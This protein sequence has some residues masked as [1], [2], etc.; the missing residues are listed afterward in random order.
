MKTKYLLAA[1]AA[2]AAL[3]TMAT[4]AFAQSTGSA[5]FEEGTII[6][7][8]TLERDVAGVEIPD[9]PKA[10]VQIDSELIQR[11][12]PGQTINDTLNLVP[13][14]SF[15]N[16][17][18]FGSLGGSF[19]IR[20]FSSDRISQTFDGVPLNDSGNYALYTNQQLDPEI[21]EAATVSLG[22]TDVDSP[23]A[24]AA[25]GTINIRS[26]VPDDVMGAM[27][28][29]SYGNIISRGDPGDRPFLRAFGKIETGELTAGGL[30]AFFSASRA[31]NDSVFSN[32]GG[33][34]KQQYNAK[35]YQPIGVDGD[36]ISIAGHYNENRNN[37]NGSPFRYSGE[38]GPVQEPE[39]R[40]YNLTDG[41]PCAIDLPQTGVQDSYN[42]CGTPFERR[43]NPS[44]T[45]NVRI[46]SLFTLS[47]RLTLT[48]DP[49][50]QYV[51]ANGGGTSVGYEGFS[52]GGYTGG[53][54]TGDSR[55]PR[56]M[57]TDSEGNVFYSATQVYY[58]G[59]TDLNG[60]GDLLDFVTILSPS[61][62]R[63]NRYG[64]IANLIYELS[65]TQRV[66]LAYTFDR[67]RHRQTGTAGSLLGN[68]EPVDVFPIN[69]P[70][71]DANG[72]APQKR[73]RLSYATLHQVS[74]EYRGEFGDLTALVGLRAPFFTRDLNQYCVTT[75]SGGNVN[76][77]N[78]D[79]DTAAYVAANAD[80]GY[81]GPVSDK[82][83]YNKILPNVGFTYAIGSAASVFANF[84]KNLS[85]PGTD[86]LYGSL[87][88]GIAPAPETSDAFDVGVRYQSGSV[89]AQLS[90]WFNRYQNRLAS[91]YSPDCDCT[92]TRNLGQ[93]DKYGIDGSVAYQPI[94]A[95]SLYVFGS[96]L[97]SEIKDDVQT[98]PAS[99]AATAGKREAGAPKYMLGARAQT[100]LGPIQLGLQGKKTG[101]RFLNDINTIELPGYF[102]MDA[103]LRVAFGYWDADYE[104]AFLQ[105]NVTNILD[106]VYIGSAP[107][108]LTT[109]GEFVNIG[110]PRAFTAS[111][112]FGF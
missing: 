112:V 14:V 70:L 42:S 102:T 18:P 92:I 41:T 53:I 1:S 111:L 67:A 23:T 9:S 69:D 63:T 66:R 52:Q 7:S 75:D 24:S 60:D 22:S 56:R 110:S 55:D 34:D 13:G 16:N 104:N 43:Y 10:K 93:V 8:G 99:F 2:S 84:A 68:G 95:L 19:T 45:G 72:V 12:V 38:P 109:S 32:Y 37:F 40:F 57:R 80:R 28:S 86:A 77:I 29:L 11:Q 21:I 59:G 91:A 71:L 83:D 50:F 65:D 5:D 106:K 15:T 87:Y 98:G 105:F 100:D 54:F 107:T 78:G 27:V 46:N 94:D 20:G 26:K 81:V 97:K 74:A 49:S 76:C 35:I 30:K 108:G 103:D 6:V 51:K 33:V 96:Y 48:I 64:V 47:D 82:Y 25:G 36:F 17:D 90:G 88:A 4:P 62:T 89:Q 61:H 58:F 73:N 101:S 44:N 79:A 39:D 85:V 31:V 3:A